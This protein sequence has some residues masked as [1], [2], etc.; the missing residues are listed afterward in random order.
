MGIEQS[1]ELN[2]AKSEPRSSVAGAGTRVAQSFHG[3]PALRQVDSFRIGLP[4][5]YVG[6]QYLKVMPLPFSILISLLF[7]I[8][9]VPT[10]AVGA[11]GFSGAEVYAQSCAM[12]H[13]NGVGGAPKL[14]EAPEWRGRITQGRADLLVSVLRGKGGMPPKGGNASLSVND[15]NAA[16]DYMLVNSLK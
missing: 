9:V 7:P 16:L 1:P 10:L 11:D 6:R 13:A 4:T 8:L 2:S 14:G 5:G 12:C 3:R 15:V